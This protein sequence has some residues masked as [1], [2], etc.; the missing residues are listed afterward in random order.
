VKVTCP[1]RNI[2]RRDGHDLSNLLTITDKVAQKHCN[3]FI[4]SKMKEEYIN[5]RDNG[6]G[7]AGLCRTAGRRFAEDGQTLGYK[8]YFNN[9]KF[10]VARKISRRKHNK[11]EINVN[12]ANMKSSETVR[13][14][15]NPVTEPTKSAAMTIQTRSADIVHRLTAQCIH[16]VLRESKVISSFR[17]DWI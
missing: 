10:P 16:R 5:T 2:F 11:P 13:D 14:G 12:I 6:K 8:Y 4:A 9:P 7:V 15:S 17:S 3:Q 1:F